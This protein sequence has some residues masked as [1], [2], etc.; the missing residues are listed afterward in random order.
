M[1]LPIFVLSGVLVIISVVC[2]EAMGFTVKHFAKVLSIV[3]EYFR[4]A[5]FL[6]V[7]EL[8]DILALLIGF[9]APTIAGTLLEIS[10]VAESVFVDFLSLSLLFSILHFP[11]IAQTIH[12]QHSVAI[13]FVVFEFPLHNNSSFLVYDFTETVQLE[14]FEF[15]S[16][17]NFL[18]LIWVGRCVRFCEGANIGPNIHGVVLG[19]HFDLAEA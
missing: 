18:D 7:L 19:E 14:V 17:E 12:S 3:V 9:Q 16:D 11:D 2:S 4:K 6:P 10:N 5:G 8:T 13:H 1:K 15:T